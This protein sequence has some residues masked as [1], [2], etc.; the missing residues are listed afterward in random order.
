MSLLEAIASDFRSFGAS[1]LEP[2]EV[3]VV[4]SG[5]DGSHPDLLGRII[6]AF[7]VDVV[8]GAAV[9]T[10]VSPR[11]NNDRYG[12]GTA[13]ASIIARLAPNA[14]IVDI[15]V[16]GAGNVG[17]G[18]ALIG[19]FRHAVERR[20]RVVNM[21]LASKATFAPRLNDLCEQA[22]RR[23]QVIVASK[24][25]HPLVDLGYPAELAVSVSVDRSQ[26]ESPFEIAFRPDE[27]IEFVAHGTEVVVAAAGGGYTKM[28]GTS[29]A[30]PTISGL[31]ALLLGRFPGLR[32]FEVKSA[33][34]AQA[35]RAHSAS[36]DERRDASA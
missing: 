18:E 8:E 7:S 21:S 10:P 1:R 33:L 25:N 15:R 36:A 26:Y 32:P 24:R 23:N 13:V 34:K 17:S 28:T 35:E 11:E 12:H 14:R 6:E 5:V 31:C 29:F 16:L 22:Y 20:S 2:V 19:G 27:V 30:T 3:A 4:D 9:V